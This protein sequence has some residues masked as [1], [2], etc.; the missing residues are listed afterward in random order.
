MNGA[1]IKDL[2][3]SMLA[4]YHSF[5][6]SQFP[7][8]QLTQRKQS[9]QQEACIFISLPLLS[10]SSLEA[11]QCTS[12]QTRQETVNPL[13]PAAQTESCCSTLYPFCSIIPSYRLHLRCFGAF[14]ASSLRLLE[15][16]CCRCSGHDAIRGLA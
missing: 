4:S 15:A 8:E 14:V 5:L 16:L 1:V 6:P 11:Y 10:S 9:R 13:R 3:V 2:S 7:Q 12:E